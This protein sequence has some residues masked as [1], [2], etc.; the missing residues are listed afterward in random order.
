MF[1]LEKIKNI[2]HEAYTIG[3]IQKL[4]NSYVVA[5]NL[6]IEGNCSIDEIKAVKGVYDE[7]HGEWENKIA[8]LNKEF[9]E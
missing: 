1:D 5:I 9:E 8:G 3:G 7:L 4:N 6:A 2:L